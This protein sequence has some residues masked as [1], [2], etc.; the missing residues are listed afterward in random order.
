DPERLGGLD[1]RT[2]GKDVVGLEREVRMLLGRADG[3]HDPVV[4]GQ[5]GLELHPV[6]VADPHR[7]ARTLTPKPNP[8]LG[9]RSG[10]SLESSSVGDSNGAEKGSPYRGHRSTTDGPSSRSSAPGRWRRD[11]QTT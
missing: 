2:L 5:V 10:T 3:E 11:L 8:W 1:G 9:Q 6:E 4:S 7:D